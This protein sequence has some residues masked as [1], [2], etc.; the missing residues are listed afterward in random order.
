MELTAVLN[1][2]KDHSGSVV[3]IRHH[4]GTSWR[5]YNLFVASGAVRIV[6]VRLVMVAENET[7][8]LSTDLLSVLGIVIAAIA[9]GVS[10]ATVLLGRR[11]RRQDM[12]IR[13]QEMLADEKMQTGR[14][15]LYQGAVTENRVV[16][17]TP[18]GGLVYRTIRVHSTVAMYVRRGL[19]PR[20]WVLEAWHHSLR[21]MRPGL[22]TYV[23]QQEDAA[24]RWYVASELMG[25]IEMAER[26][27]SSLACCRNE[28]A[29]QEC[30]E[31]MP[32]GQ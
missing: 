30:G 32:F 21:N 2:H 13:V 7:V 19:V 22:T 9:V 8:R 23:A 4:G 11:Q 6:H 16:R 15:L 28:A 27:R 31:S 14:W 3:P 20:Q 26:Y 25:L 18:E 10:F 1:F 24:V 12:F 29:L 5:S 17:G